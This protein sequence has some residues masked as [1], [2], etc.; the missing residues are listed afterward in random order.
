MVDDQKLYSIKLTGY[1][2]DVGQPKDY[3]QG[4][5][6]HLGH[7]KLIKD[8]SLAIENG[9][10]IIGNVLIHPS[11]K[12]S[13]NCLLG[14][15]VSIGENAEIHDGVRIKES[16]V[17]SDVVVKRNAYINGTII[18]WGTNIGAWSRIEP[19]TVI[20]EEVNVK[21]EI[22]INGASICPH[23][24]VDSHITQNGTILM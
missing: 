12:I 15:N 13:P 22:Y 6:L 20:G 4:I 8:P 10:N 3:I 18:G 9:K 7:L 21:D 5:K 19:T 23:K 24:D 14:P 17:F 16:A 2:M 11:A 1:W